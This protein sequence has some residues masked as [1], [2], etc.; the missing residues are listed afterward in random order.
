MNL[1]RYTAEVSVY[2]SKQPYFGSA[3]QAAAPHVI[4]P[5]NGIQSACTGLC[6]VES[7]L[8]E[9]ACLL[10]MP[11]IFSFGICIGDVAAAFTGCLIG[12]NAG[13]GNG[14]GG[15]G[16]NCSETGCPAGKFCCECSGRCFPNTAVGHGVCAQVCEH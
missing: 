2:R 14:G 5:A 9:F 7:G 3:A 12:C 10:L 4:A 13:G 8:G 11:D 16:G 1:P 6:A 15:G